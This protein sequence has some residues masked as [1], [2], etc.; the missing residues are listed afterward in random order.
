MH[1]VEIKR[2]LFKKS[3]GTIIFAIVSFTMVYPSETIVAFS[4]YS[5]IYF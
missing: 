5:K 4:I 2:M 1:L 3:I